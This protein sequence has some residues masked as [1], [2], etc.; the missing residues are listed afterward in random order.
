MVT[1]ARGLLDRDAS[2]GLADQGPA[3]HRIAGA[4]KLLGRPCPAIPER[5]DDDR[6]AGIALEKTDHHLAADIGQHKSAVIPS[7]ERHRD[8]RPER[9]GLA[10]KAGPAENLDLDPV[11]VF[12]IVDRDHL[13]QADGL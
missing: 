12:G 6:V 9:A 10:A 7:R 2:A 11:E 5:S 8:P 1:A 13:G 4:A 3:I